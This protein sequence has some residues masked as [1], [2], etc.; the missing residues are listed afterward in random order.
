MEYF[1]L[2]HSVSS[3]ICLRNLINKK[4]APSLVII[5]KNYE[6]ENLAKDFYKPINKL[7]SLY[8][9][10]LIESDNL[11]DIKD[12]IKNFDVGICVGYMNILRKD[13]FE[14][15]NYG[16]F[17][18]HCGKL[19]KYRGRAPISRT[20]KNGDKDLVITLHKMDEGVDSGDIAV[21][22]KI[23]ITLKDDVNS[24][25]KKF[26]DNSHKPIIELLNQLKRNKIKLKKQR[27]PA[28]SKPYRK[29][30]EAE[31]RID[32]S[33][34]QKDIFNQIRALKFPYPGAFSELNGNKYFLLNSNLSKAKSTHKPGVINKIENGNIYM[35]TKDFVLKISDVYNVNKKINVKKEFQTGEQFI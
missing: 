5:H 10:K 17:N 35:N 16:I 28:G 30:T 15:P 1:Y 26:S 6:S 24:L 32:W 19:P 18:L 13:F 29:L 23:R 4:H 9:I 8:K 31:C 11:S 2:A 3:L 33:R 27:I 7:C 25:Y 14:I 12:R 20:I 22:N 21:E 34:S